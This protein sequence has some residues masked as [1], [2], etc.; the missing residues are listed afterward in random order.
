MPIFK[1]EKTYS[2]EML[3]PD[4]ETDWYKEVRKSIK[5]DDPSGCNEKVCDHCGFHEIYLQSLSKTL[6]LCGE[7]KMVFYCSSDCQRK[8]WKLHRP[9][10]KVYVKLKLGA[11]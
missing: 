1:G 6:K 7:C 8:A 9:H 2:I 11:S 5:N 10:C 3:S 4:K